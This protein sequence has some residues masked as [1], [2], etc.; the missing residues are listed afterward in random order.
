M[1]VFT[2]LT[3]KEIDQFIQNYEI[4]KLKSY[5]EIIEGIENSNYKII[6][7]QNKYILT[8]FEKRV[9]TKDIPF[10][11]D[12]QNHL[13]SNVFKCPLPIKNKS[14]NIINEIKDKKAILIS[15]LE[16]KKIIKP[17]TDN[18]FQVGKM[19]ANFQQITKSF[20]KQ[21]KNNL[22]ISMWKKIFSKCVKVKNHKHINLIKPIEKELIYLN[23]NW[24]KKLPKGIIHAD[25]F[26]DNIFFK[27]SNLSG[28]IDFYFSCVDFYSYEL[29]ITTNAWCFDNNQN[30]IKKNF[31][32]LIE[33]Y[34]CLYS[35]KKQE[36]E[37]YN[38][39]LR[40]AAIRILLTRLHD[41]IFHPK[42]AIV[43]PKNPKEY[44]KILQWHQNNSVFDK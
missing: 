10:F 33:G 15:Y 3:K 20:K 27:K 2:K 17:S 36:I 32:S 42:D 16:G 6:T 35:L 12:L 38:I 26:K 4:G 30:F 39:L 41:Y 13:S 25:L 19:I 44:F 5:E 22:S 8:I 18:C 43:V 21:R 23:K 34:N 29:A 14:G 40:G 9:K 24:P 37:N 11:I 28:V 7:N 1:A 31:F